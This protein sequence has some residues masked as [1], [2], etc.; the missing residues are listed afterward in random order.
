MVIFGQQYNNRSFF[1]TE[2]FAIVIRPW[3]KK[4][5]IIEPFKFFMPSVITTAYEN[6]QD[7]QKPENGVSSRVGL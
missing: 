3:H 1:L 6:E 4:H 2:C 7:P 5:I